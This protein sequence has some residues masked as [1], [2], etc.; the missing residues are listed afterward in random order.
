[1]TRFLD[2]P[3]GGR[4]LSLRRAPHFLRVTRDKITGELDALDQ[5]QDQPRASEELICY[6]LASRPVSVFIRPGGLRMLANYQVRLPQPTD[7]DM[8]A[9]PAWRAWCEANRPPEMSP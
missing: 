3:A 2:G 9:T 4:V 8:R 6:V 7:A 1:M 5:L